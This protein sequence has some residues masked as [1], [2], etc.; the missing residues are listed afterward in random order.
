MCE[1]DNFM[2]S[3][4]FTY[5]RETRENYGYR[6]SNISP[7]FVDRYGNKRG[8]PA[9]PNTAGE[10]RQEIAHTERTQSFLLLPLPFVTFVFRALLSVTQLM[11]GDILHRVCCSP[12]VY[13]INQLAVSIKQTTRPVTDSVIEAGY[14]HV[15]VTKRPSPNWMH[16]CQPTTN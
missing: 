12:I 5:T 10:N 8:W 11:L 14:I 1:I 15:Y 9:S 3:V 13:I 4:Q 6:C 7:S 16:S 2:I